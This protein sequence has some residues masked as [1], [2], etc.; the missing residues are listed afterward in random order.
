MMSQHRKTR[1]HGAWR[2]G[3]HNLHGNSCGDRHART[4][5]LSMRST[6]AA[7]EINMM[8]AGNTP[9][10]HDLQGEEQNKLDTE[11]G[12]WQVAAKQA[13]RLSAVIVGARSAFMRLPA[14]GFVLLACKQGYG[15]K[16]CD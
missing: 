9:L 2:I 1:T 10:L 15:A 6:R 13:W 11:R 8:Y 7:A 16:V 4:T 12:I 3:V 5:S 14:F